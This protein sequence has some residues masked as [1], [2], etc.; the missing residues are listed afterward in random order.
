MSS[1]RTEPYQLASALGDVRSL[2]VNDT[3]A[4]VSSDNGVTMLPFRQK[5]IRTRE[6]TVDDGLV[7]SYVF[8]LYLD[9]DYLWIGS[10]R[11]LTRF[12]WNDPD[13]ID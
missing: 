10:D 7:S 5:R 6:F 4:M 3:V 12:L 2:A 9:G 8:S 11:G 13:L 1:G